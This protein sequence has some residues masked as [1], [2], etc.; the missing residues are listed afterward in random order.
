MDC[1]ARSRL[2]GV[3][4]SGTVCDWN[5]LRQFPHFLRN[6]GRVLNASGSHATAS[7]SKAPRAGLCQK[8]RFPRPS[9]VLNYEM[10]FRDSP[11]RSGLNQQRDALEQERRQIAEQRNRDPIVAESIQAAA[12]LLAAISPL[13]VCLVLLRSLL[14]GSDEDVLADLLIE[15]LV[16]QHPLLGDFGFFPSG[17]RRRAPGCLPSDASSSNLGVDSRRSPPA[18]GSHG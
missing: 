11:Q 4:G 3:L 16:A 8:P 12:G 7:Q 15:D 18:D 10:S 17:E 2:S 9:G 14:Y 5:S 1:E 6:A 13:P